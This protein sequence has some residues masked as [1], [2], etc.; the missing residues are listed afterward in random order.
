MAGRVFK[1]DDGTELREEDVALVIE[2]RHEGFPSPI[3]TA[4]ARLRAALAPEM[5]GAVMTS[6]VSGY[7]FDGRY[8]CKLSPGHPGDHTPDHVLW[9]PS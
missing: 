9:W 8:R 6:N 7:S 5:C 2:A 1:A 4:V 3:F